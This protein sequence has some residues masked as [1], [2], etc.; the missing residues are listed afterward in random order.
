MTSFGFLQP[1]WNLA[2]ISIIEKNL[3]VYNSLKEKREARTELRML[4]S[5]TLQKQNL[6]SVGYSETWPES[7]WLRLLTWETSAFRSAHRGWRCLWTTQVDRTRWRGREPW[8]PQGMMPVE[9]P[10]NQPTI[11]RIASI[12]FHIFFISLRSL[13]MI[14]WVP[15]RKKQRGNEGKSHAMSCTNGLISFSHSYQHLPISRN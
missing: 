13:S 8:A 7:T 11:T 9:W 6:K 2:S 1:K 12:C 10:C 5:I 3:L 15:S 14:W 4:L